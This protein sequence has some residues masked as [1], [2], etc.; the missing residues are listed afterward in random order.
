MILDV[1]GR[2]VVYH[3]FHLRFHPYRSFGSTQ[4]KDTEGTNCCEAKMVTRLL[5]CFSRTEISNLF[6]SFHW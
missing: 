2:L 4:I 1:F 6:I 5:T 3:Q